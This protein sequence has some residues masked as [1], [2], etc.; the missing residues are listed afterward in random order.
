MIN[1]IS[2]LHFYLKEIGEPFHAE[3]AGG[4]DATVQK[5]FDGFIQNGKTAEQFYRESKTLLYHL[6]WFGEDQWKKPYHRVIRENFVPPAT[7][8]D[9]GCSVASD[10]LKFSEL[11][12]DVKFM[13]MESECT[14]F[15]EWRLR[16]H[17]IKDAKVHG[18]NEP[19]DKADLV[20]A[21]DVVEHVEDP[22]KLLSDIERRGKCVAVNFL[23]QTGELADGKEHLHYH[24]DA[25]ELVDWVKG[26]SEI[27]QVRNFDY[28][29]FLIYRP[30]EQI[31]IPE[32]ATRVRR[33]VPAIISPDHSGK[34]VID[35]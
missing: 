34:E 15:A 25:Q 2:D 23:T 4:N 19:L 7:M 30:N 17:G 3:W 26:H 1:G 8:L 13:D 31:V 27:I 6:T 33:S 12:Y 18:F 14:K 24:H 9:Y 11:G 22:K 16:T 5:E 35:V 10:G 28:A 21:F 32:R 20:F 29:I